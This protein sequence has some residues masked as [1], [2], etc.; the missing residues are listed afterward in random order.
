MD[1]KIKMAFSSVTKHV[2]ITAFK[3]I[4]FPLVVL[5][6]IVHLMQLYDA[7]GD[8]CGRL[9]DGGTWLDEGVWQPS[10]CMLHKY[11]K[12]EAEKCLANRKVAFVG[13]SRQRELFYSFVNF[14]SSEKFEEIPKAH[15]DIPFKSGNLNVEFLWR[16]E[17]NAS[18]IDL[19][20]NWLKEEGKPMVV[21]QSAGVHTMKRTSGSPLGVEGFKSNLTKLKLNMDS[22]M[23][24][25][26][27]VYWILQDPVNENKLSN[28]RSSI[29]NELISEY[30]AVAM[31]VFHANGKIP[32]IRSLADL[33]GA[34]ISKSVDGLHLGKDITDIDVSIL[35]NLLCNQMTHATDGTCCRKPDP[36]TIVQ[37]IM[38]VLGFIF[39]LLAVGIRIQRIGKPTPT[40]EDEVAKNKDSIH[41]IIAELTYA[42]AKMSLIL[43]YF[44]ICDRTDVFMK[45]NKHYTN[46]RFFLPLLYIVFL[47]IF[48]IDST[49]Q[50]VFLNRD[51]TDEWKGWMQLVI[52]IYHVTGASVNVP[53]YMHV[54]LLVAMY[55]FMTGYGHFSYFWNKGDFGVHRVFGVMF[56]LNFLTVMLCLTMDRSY[57]F[58]YFVPMC[59]FWF[60]VLYL[61]MALWPRAYM[62]A[63][64][65]E[66]TLSDGET[67]E[68]TF[69][70]PIFVMCAKLS[71]LLFTIVLVFLSQELFESMFSWWPVIRLFELP[72][73]MV[74]EWW[75]RCHLDRFA[76]LHGAVFAFGY[77]ILKRLSIVDDS[78]QGCLLSTKVSLIAVTASIL[79]TLFYSVWALQCSDKQSC[80]EVH[81]FASL[82][83]I[84]AFILIRN[85]PG[86]LRAGYSS[87]F[88]WFGKISLELFIGQYHIWLAADTKGILVITSPQWPMLNLLVSTFVFVCVAHEISALTGT[89]A[90]YLVGPA[91][92]ADTKTVCAKILV[93]TAV[94]VCF[95]LI[96]DLT[97]TSPRV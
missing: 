33:A 64:N 34:K 57:Q 40:N 14:V 7:G 23:Q 9:L 53:I 86:Y 49:K 68:V 78:R 62:V 83:P 84:S 24:K 10:G 1:E 18:A 46:T 75:F 88:A 50:P 72:P 59:S 31:E 29:T 73:G 56:R 85:I 60:L 30:N 65:K 52:L 3:K 28:A 95:M 32:V 81:S 92:T 21:F 74:R 15:F 37:I 5:L 58:Y 13:D 94:L 89:F 93:I 67:K 6:I 38:A 87:F 69:T 20:N 43:F 77:I 51:Q 41:N 35:L 22:L 45:S 63:T 55:L 12:N 47:G 17:P 2:N 79:C 36:L 70:S 44:Y 61:F 97:N 48:G 4:A 54:R 91:K 76:M 11:K 8:T 66:T 39:I 42:A 90:K 27:K 80:N 25:G 19:Y 26:T 16:P 82:I 96:S 71:L